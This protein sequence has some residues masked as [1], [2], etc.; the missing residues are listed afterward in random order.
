MKKHIMLK[1]KLNDEHRELSRTIDNNIPNVAESF[2][3]DLLQKRYAS[4]KL[5]KAA[6]FTLIKTFYKRDG[7]NLA[8]LAVQLFIND[9]DSRLLKTLDKKVRE[10][11]L[12]SE[13][14]RPEYLKKLNN[15]K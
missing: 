6:A 8:H 1:R 12:V 15:H 10:E 7:I 5:T 13:S 3:I 11:L 2:V 4:N 14:T 9:V